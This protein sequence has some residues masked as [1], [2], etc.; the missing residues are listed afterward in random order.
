MSGTGLLP[1]GVYPPELTEAA[2][3][4]KTGGRPSALGAELAQAER[5]YARIDPAALLPSTRQPQSLTALELAVIDCHSHLTARVL[6]LQDQLMSLARIARRILAEYK[7]SRQGP[8]PAAAELGDSAAAFAQACAAVDWSQDY[9]DTRARIEAASDKADLMVDDAAA[10]LIRA[11]QTYE[12]GPQRAADWQALIRP[13]GHR[14]SQIVSALPDYRA[15]FW[16]KFKMFQSFD[17]DALKL[18]G[19]EEIDRTKRLAVLG[20]AVRQTEAIA[21]HE[22]DE[23][24]K[25]TQASPLAD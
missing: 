20:Q 18:E 10:R 16:H 25:I 4:A 9:E 5:L 2:W 6:P 15:R 3:A 22:P 17:I 19:T 13:E 21:D 8:G 24:G 23:P 7:R 1:L 12:Q 14:L 11:A